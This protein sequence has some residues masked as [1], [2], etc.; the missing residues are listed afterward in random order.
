MILEIVN[1]IRL[2]LMVAV[3]FENFI[4]ELVQID[5][6]KFLRH[7]IALWAFLWLE[8]N[9]Y[10]LVNL[11]GDCVTRYTKIPL[12]EALEPKDFVE[13]NHSSSLNIERNWYSQ[14]PHGIAFRRWI[15]R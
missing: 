4:R 9:K 6:L 2:I 11:Q 10:N 7:F 12:H 8:N 1:L 3:N 13:S 14:W 15:I 5:T